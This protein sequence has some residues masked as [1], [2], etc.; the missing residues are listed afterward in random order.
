[1]ASLGAANAADEQLPGSAVTAAQ[2]PQVPAGTD[3]PAP[4]AAAGE[5]DAQTAGAGDLSSEAQALVAAQTQAG[6]EGTTQTAEDSQTHGAPAAGALPI[7]APTSQTATTSAAPA[8]STTAAASAPAQPSPLP[9]GASPAQSATGPRAS[10]LNTT[11]STP[12]AASLPSSGS[13]GESTARAIAGTHTETSAEPRLSVPL[14]TSSS[15]SP[16][17]VADMQAPVAQA[18]GGA[19]GAPVL[20]YGVGLQQAIEAVH[21]TIELATRQGLTQARIALSP[22]ELGEIRI[23]LSQSTQGLI[24]RVTADTPAAAQ[25]LAENHS[26]LRQSLDS[27][28]LTAL[29]MDGSTFSQAGTQQREGLSHQPFSFTPNSERSS[30]LSG[31]EDL[32]PDATP[33]SAEAASGLSHGALIDVLA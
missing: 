33:G 32:L 1:M 18:A 28:G 7:L 29:H 2:T 11:T 16:I 27:L 4:M 12:D 31:D 26:E 9:A 10:L 13:L 17:A 8:S 3:A 30:S 21:A 5:A 20:S 24:A 15:P 14:A 6:R 19:E 25:A 22:A 23:H